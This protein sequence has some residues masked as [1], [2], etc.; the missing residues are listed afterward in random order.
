LA[1][2]AYTTRPAPIARTGVPAALPQSS[3][4]W[5]SWLSGLPKHGPEPGANGLTTL[6]PIRQAEPV[7]GVIHALFRSAMDWK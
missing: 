7:S 6:K 1:N 2:A 3:P 4:E 5:T